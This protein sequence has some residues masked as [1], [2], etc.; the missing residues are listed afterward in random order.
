VQAAAPYVPASERDF[1]PADTPRTE[2]AR[3]QGGSALVPEE[4]VPPAYPREAFFN[5][6]QQGTVRARLVIGASGRVERVEVAGVTAR[7]RVFE[8]AASQALST[9]RFA[10][11]E[12]GRIYETRLEFRA[13]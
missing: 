10:P 7:D 5:G 4:R 12:A 6:I 13:P 8:R 1:A 3:A 2:I 9:W 11:G